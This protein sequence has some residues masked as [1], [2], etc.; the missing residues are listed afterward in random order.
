M[1]RQHN[2]VTF[3]SVLRGLTVGNMLGLFPSPR[4]SQ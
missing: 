3:L 1:K 4:L 2:A